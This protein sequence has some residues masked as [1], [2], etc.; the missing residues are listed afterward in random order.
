M[1][2]FTTAFLCFRVT[3]AL[4]HCAVV[5]RMLLYVLTSL[6]FGWYWVVFACA[7]LVICYTAYQCSSRCISSHFDLLFYR[8]CV[9]VCVPLDFCILKKYQLLLFPVLVCVCVCVHNLLNYIEG[10]LCNLLSTRYQMSQQ[11]NTYLPYCILIYV[12]SISLDN[13]WY[14][15][16]ICNPIVML[17]SKQYG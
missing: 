3:G 6:L 13:T 15:L 16:Q 14:K 4:I 5:I 11:F 1:G 7:R 9:C 8:D 10:K 2:T 12:V 17:Y